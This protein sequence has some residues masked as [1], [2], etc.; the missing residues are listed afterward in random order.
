MSYKKG[1]I[2]A[3]DIVVEEKTVE[4]LDDNSRWLQIMKR[5]KSEITNSE[6][7]LSD[8]LIFPPNVIVVCPRCKEKIKLA[9]IQKDYCKIAEKRIHNEL[10]QL[11]LAI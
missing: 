3:I 10:K 2:R 7:G 11:K 1:I 6:Q 8:T 4:H 5:L 9:Q